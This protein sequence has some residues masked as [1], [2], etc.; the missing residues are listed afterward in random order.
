MGFCGALL[1]ANKFKKNNKDYY[2]KF[3]LGSG[4]QWEDDPLKALGE[5]YK[6]P[7]VRGK[8]RN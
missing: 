7:N 2:D 6:G 4:S 8:S 5:N 3:A 1:S